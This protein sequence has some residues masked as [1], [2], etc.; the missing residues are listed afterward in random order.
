M[1]GLIMLAGY[2]CVI[3][4]LFWVFHNHNDDWDGFA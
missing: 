1:T 4:T 2:L 3:A